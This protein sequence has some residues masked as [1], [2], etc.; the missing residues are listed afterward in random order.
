MAPVKLPVELRWDRGGSR[1]AFRLSVAIDPDHIT[2]ARELPFPDGELAQARFALP[3]DARTITAQVEIQS[4]AAHFRAL[5]S[6]DR[7]RIAD[8]WK[9]RLGL[10]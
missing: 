2:F 1:R 9:E 10:S 7:A 3:G 4:R 5:A 6:A 8:Y